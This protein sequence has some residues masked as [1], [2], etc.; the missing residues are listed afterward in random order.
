MVPT[1]NLTLHNLHCTLVRKRKR[2]AATT[3]DL[4][5]DDDDVADILPPT[6]DKNQETLAQHLSLKAPN[7]QGDEALAR[8]LTPNAPNVQE[9]EALARHLSPKATNVQG[10]EAL[11]RRLSQG[12][13]GVRDDEALALSLSAQWN[14]PGSDPVSSSGRSPWPA[15]AHW[16]EMQHFEGKCGNFDVCSGGSSFFACAAMDERTAHGI[17]PV[18]MPGQTIIIHRQNGLRTN[19][20]EPNVVQGRKIRPGIDG[21]VTGFCLQQTSD[22]QFTIWG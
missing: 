9:D 4:T 17:E 12:A 7:V 1:A 19:R 3:V 10:D 18:P 13:V 14:S 5:G 21:Q 20:E 2:E 8:H 11:A 16:H 6:P 22:M 15:V